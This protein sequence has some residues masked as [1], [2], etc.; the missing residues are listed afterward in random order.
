MG[1]LFNPMY[2]LKEDEGR[3]LILHKGGLSALT[4]TANS[5]SFGSAHPLH[6]AILA[7]CKGDSADEAY[8]RL[9]Q[10]I[11]IRRELFDKFVSRLLDCEDP[12]A[13]KIGEEE[14]FF[15]PMTL[16]SSDASPAK[17]L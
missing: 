14:A 16:I 1:L 11:E 7:C 17:V 15:P 3:V 5:G 8:K 12:V 10:H 13:M 9:C 6:G 2:R 4:E